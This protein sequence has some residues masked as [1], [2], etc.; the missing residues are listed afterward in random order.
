MKINK[1]KFHYQLAEFY[2]GWGGVSDNICNYFWQVIVGLFLMLVIAAAISALIMLGLDMLIS[3]MLLYV[4]LPGGIWFNMPLFISGWMLT[5]VAG[6]WV[7]SIWLLGES[8]KALSNKLATKQAKDPSLRVEWLKAK[9][10]KMCIK[11]EF[12]K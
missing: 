1:N 9:K 12:Y 2:S 4:G 7:G 11:L 5:I 8:T 3:P 10:N 6:V